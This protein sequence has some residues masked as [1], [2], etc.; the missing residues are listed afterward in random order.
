MDSKYPQA[1]A[2]IP[3]DDEKKIAAL[4][5]RGRYLNRSDLIR[6]ALRKL[7]EEEEG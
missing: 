7:F 2:K 3:V 6:A 1:T 4:I 5:E